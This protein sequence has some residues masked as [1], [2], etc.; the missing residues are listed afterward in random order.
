MIMFCVYML[1]SLSHI[2]VISF[3]NGQWPT[4]CL[5]VKI[6]VES[7]NSSLYLYNLRCLYFCSGA[8]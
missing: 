3:V 6:K 7:H 8:I 4:I 1:W 5:I 2:S